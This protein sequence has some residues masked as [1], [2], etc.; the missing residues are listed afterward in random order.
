MF[1]SVLPTLSKG[2]HT[3]AS[4]LAGSRKQA[5]GTTRKQNVIL[6]AKRA[7]EAV[8]DRPSV[9]LGTRPS[10]E[11]VKW[12]NCDLAKVL[13]DEEALFSAT[14][15]SSPASSSQTA[16]S[17][18]LHVVE[19]SV[20][21][22]LIPAQP[23]FGVAAVEADLLFNELPRISAEARNLLPPPVGAA[24]SSDKV[25]QFE[26]FAE[27]ERRKVENFSK[28]VDLRNANAAGIAFEN[29]RRIIEA[30]ST[31]ENPFDPGRA[32]VQGVYRI[33]IRI[34]RLNNAFFTAALKTYQIRKLWT[35][36]ITYKRDVGNRLGL[37]KLV[38]QRAKILRYL[39]NTNRDRYEIVL[40]RLALEPESVEGELVV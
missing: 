14:S 16:S 38:H 20:G 6:Q 36:L 3:S 17:S 18:T 35:H 30:F 7:K 22:V 37:R 5:S 32:E 10:E 1:R 19:S 40:E 9:V 27:Q 26:R 31:P 13:V 29:R 33:P 11:A 34:G 24:V 39:R 23:A 15:S 12:P 25:Q 4:A 28:V 2:F 8:A 21:E